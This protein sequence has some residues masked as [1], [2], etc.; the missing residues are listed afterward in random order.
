MLQPD[1][2]NN[3]QFPIEVDSLVLENN[4]QGSALPASFE[5]LDVFRSAESI[6]PR[7]TRMFEVDL[8][9]RGIA[10]GIN[11]CVK[12]GL[13]DDRDVVTDAAEEN[14]DVSAGGSFTIGTMSF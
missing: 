10:S 9:E 2:N 7:A 3:L 1:V 8:E 5:V 4:L 12:G 11:D 14:V 6:A 13:A